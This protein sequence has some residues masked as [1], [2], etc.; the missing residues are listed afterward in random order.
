MNRSKHNRIL[1]AGTNSGCG[2]TTVTIALIA[3]LKA[4]G[5]GTASFKCGPDYIDPMFHREALGVS[6][7]NLDPYFSDRE[8][9]RHLFCASAGSDISVIEGVMGYYDGI[10]AEGKCSTYDVASAV[11]APV[12]LIINGRGMSTSAGAILKGFAA[13]KPNNNIQGVIFN[14][15][16]GMTYPLLKEVA[17]QAGVKAYG[18][19]PKDDSCALESRNLGLVTAQEVEDIL[20]KIARLGRA[21]EASI[22]ID[23]L[24]ELAASAPE[25]ES[26][27]G[28]GITDGAEVKSEN[29][30]MANCP[31]AADADRAAEGST[32]SASSERPR[33]AVARDKAFCFIYS[34]NI[35]LLQELGCEIA[36]FSPL[37]DEKLPEDISGL[38]LCGG[39]PELYT[40]ELSDNAS[41]RE[42]IRTAIE[43]GLPTIAE[44]GGFM[45][46][47][48]SIDQIPMVGA[49]HG[50]TFR[51]QRL[52]RFGYTKITAVHDNL[53]GAAGSSIRAHEFHYY[54]SED[55][56]EDYIAEKASN[57]KTYRCCHAT[58]TLYAGY[59]HIYLPANHSF[60][61]A[62]VRKAMERM[63]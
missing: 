57:G 53:L 7:H 10:G 44:C 58:D 12:I 29:S 37:E 1:I 25:I 18:Y 51:T 49:I 35:E 22:D 50:D 62:F 9:L 56:G 48:D 52:Q 36:Y 3:A 47:H 15:I 2:K 63:R 40:R 8:G 28:Q 14:N 59:P 24:L 11:E 32:H 38:Y 27:D 21:A 16:N 13:Y 17:L 34:E 33:I 20:D 60:A 43:G 6:A 23:G 41:M 45:Y 26:A 54:D 4:R 39:Y 61:Q 19:L 30:E 46:L 55:N 31:A 42:S 5:L